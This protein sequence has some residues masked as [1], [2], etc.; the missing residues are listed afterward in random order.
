M[1][2]SLVII[3]LSFIISSCI[4][5]PEFPVVPK[6]EFRNVYFV[7]SNTDSLVVTLHFED[8]DGDLG[9][10]TDQSSFPYHQYNF[11]SVKDGEELHAKAAR[12]NRPISI[13][14]AI[15]FSDRRNVEGLDTLPPHTEPF[16]CTR[17]IR[18]P[19][20]G[21]LVNNDTV[22]VIPSLG[23]IPYPDT[24]YYNRNPFHNNIF[25]EFLLRDP[26]GNFE[27]FD[28]NQI[29]C[30]VSYN[31]RFP[32]MVDDDKEKAVEGTLTYK[33]EGKGLAFIL[34]RKIIKLRIHIVD[35]ALHKS[36]VVESQE[37][38]LSEITK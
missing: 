5:R 35:R 7:D 24:L 17:W 27:V 23:G 15:H 25:I 33:M 12:L 21:D 13:A 11:Y 34:D 19:A 8:G 2:I 6:I 18:G 30:G 29:G 16:S 3:F 31:G 20:I 36:N 22:Y 9:L 10:R 37:F 38:I 28:W 4:D 32:V 14:E 1:R 26:Q